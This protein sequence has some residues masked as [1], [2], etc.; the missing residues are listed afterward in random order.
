MM[1][2]H[3]GKDRRE[4]AEHLLRFDTF[5]QRTDMVSADDKRRTEAIMEEFGSLVEES[6]F[7][8]RAAAKAQ[9]EGREAGMIEAL[10]KAVVEI[11]EERFPPLAQLPERQ[12]AQVNEPQMLHQLVKKVSS[13]PDEAAMRSVL[14]A[15]AA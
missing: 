7:V 15:L 1:K 13:A 3:Y 11:V 5:L 8:K 9:A 2:D 6:R 12:V 10:Q 4:F 14:T